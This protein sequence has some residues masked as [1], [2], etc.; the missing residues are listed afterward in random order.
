MI[1]VLYSEVAIFCFIILGFI[2]H[3]VKNTYS[4]GHE[5]FLKLTIV[6]AVYAFVDALWGICYLGYINFGRVFFCTVSDIYFFLSGGVAYLGFLYIQKILKMDVMNT[7]R[8][9]F[10]GRLPL[11][12][13]TLLIIINHWKG[14]IFFFDEAGKYTRGFMF[15]YQFIVAYFYFVWAVILTVQRWL[16]AKREEVR[17]LCK[18]VISF[19]GIPLLLGVAQSVV[20][21]KPYFSMAY[22]LAVIGIFIFITSRDKEK[23]EKERAVRDA[24]HNRLLQQALA[25][26]QI[27]NRAKSTFL[28][29]MSH[30]IRTPMNAI[31]GFN[32]IARENIADTARVEDCLEKMDV[33]SKHLLDLINDVLDMARI[34]NDKID[35]EL[36]PGS[37][38]KLVGETRAMFMP[39][40]NKKKLCFSTEM[41][42]VKYDFLQVDIIRIRQIIFN[43]LSNAMKYTKEGGSVRFS[44]EESE[45]SM[46]GYVTL[47]MEVE[48]TGIGMSEEFQK[49]IFGM[50][51]R[52]RSTTQSG[53]Q[54]SG[55]G[56]A[57]TK[58]L[59][60]IM[61]GKISVKSK[62]GEG[63][64]FT[65]EIPFQ[66]AEAFV[67]EERNDAG[68]S[69]EGKRLLVVEDNEMN[70]EIATVILEGHGFH[71][72]ICSD[73]EM[74]VERVKNAKP[75]EFDLVL[76]DIQMPI[77]DG[78]E[79]TRRIRALED[80]DKASIPIV[81]MTANAFQKD[82][83]D[84]LEAGMNGHISKPISMEQIQEVFCQ[85]FKG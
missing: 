75:G 29:N 50:F 5:T 33:A 26:A 84:A 44:V 82:K 80:A 56:L 40:M 25:E 71:V 12:L 27:A 45:M 18:S 37:I 66:V 9:L 78:Y 41:H 83:R 81:A 17:R 32:E 16:Q 39:E 31:M 79:A 74:A 4:K 38:S 30:D 3:R 48:D 67:E 34:E 15:R 54:G 35:L 2:F 13:L 11:T 60:D 49:N 63:S 36:A 7:A 65:V 23:L 69:Y 19:T 1:N 22:T 8:R 73:G 61:D 76:M 59:V 28:F 24:E 14:Y 20:P 52:E 42:N 62:V 68:N 77:M 72:E 47:T 46:E 58:R 70:Q 21:S 85:I 6:S 53:I 55:L 51:E 43:I 64:V 57:I 10:W